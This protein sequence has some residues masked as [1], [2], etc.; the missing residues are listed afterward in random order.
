MAWLWPG[1]ELASLRLRIRWFRFSIS[2]STERSFT[3]PYFYM[4][5][6]ELK[7]RPPKNMNRA[8]ARWFIDGGFIF[9]RALGRKETNKALYQSQ[10]NLWVNHC[11][12]GT[13]ISDARRPHVFGSEGTLRVCK[14]PCYP[15]LLLR[16][17][18]S[19]YAT[20][21]FPTIDVRY[22]ASEAE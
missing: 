3:Q 11:L 1:C 14:L 19:P 4:P 5:H 18:K 12:S 22:Q 2:P 17:G 7:E 21:Q 20:I 13:K 10:S 15:L 9:N 6:G 8:L 16:F